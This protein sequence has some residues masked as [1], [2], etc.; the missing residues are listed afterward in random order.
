MSDGV[1]QSARD[2]A[3][4]AISLI[5]THERVCTERQGHIIDNLRDLKTGVEGLYRRFWAAA[6]FIISLLLSACGALIY[7]VLAGGK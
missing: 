5:E 6:L 7:L 4:K 2:N 3:N 1:D